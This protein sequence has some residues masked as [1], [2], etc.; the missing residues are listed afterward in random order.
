MTRYLLLSVILLTCVAV[1]SASAGLFDTGGG[2]LPNANL[3][4]GYFHSLSNGDN[5]IGGKVGVD[6]W[7][8]QAGIPDT[9]I[10]LSGDFI[11]VSTTDIEVGTGASL[12]LRNTRNSISFGLSYL[13]G[14]H[15]FC[16]NVGF[17]NVSF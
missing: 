5:F 14:E 11:A 8:W 17:I 10:V 15:A 7:E 12:T 4:A 3:A 6:L 16:A 9:K 13:F 1:S 2:V